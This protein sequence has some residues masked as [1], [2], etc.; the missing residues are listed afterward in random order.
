M[1]KKAITTK[2]SILCQNMSNNSISDSR[3]LQPI[4]WYNHEIGKYYSELREL[5]PRIKRA[6]AKGNKPKLIALKEIREAYNTLKVFYLAYC[7][8]DTRRLLIMDTL[9]ALKEERRRAYESE[10]RKQN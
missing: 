5:M 1:E 3:A 8:L 7:E 2:C 9:S 6:I 10:P 4:E